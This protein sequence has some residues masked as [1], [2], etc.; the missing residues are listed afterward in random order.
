[1]PAPERQRKHD[2]ALRTSCAERQIWRGLP[3]RPQREVAPDPARL[4]RATT[5]LV[6]KYGVVWL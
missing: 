1:M 4:E 5:L 3:S 6:S 2:H